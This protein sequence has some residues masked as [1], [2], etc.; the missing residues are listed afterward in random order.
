[1]EKAYKVTLEVF[2]QIRKEIIKLPTEEELATRIRI[3]GLEHGCE[4]SFDPIVASGKNSAIPHHKP[5]KDK[6]KKHVPIVL[7]FGFK[8][9]GYCSDFTRTVFIG[10]PSKK[11]QD[12]YNMVNNS[13]K[14]A[15]HAARPGMMG[16][17]L[18]NVARKELKKEK[19]YFIHS[20][21][22]G[23]GLE[24]HEAPGVGPFSKDVLEN[25]M[26]FSIEPGLYYQ[27]KGGVRIEDLVYLEKGKVK[28]FEYA[29]TDLKDNIL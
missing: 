22:H 4:I 28:Y 29:S 17:E 11:W 12:V 7:D 13:Y 24:V 27:R 1:M 19:K 18:D 14:N 6:L 25:G 16:S 26:V 2:R 3:L 5:G 23:T 20:L 10:Q 9:R 15:F 21:G 8:Y